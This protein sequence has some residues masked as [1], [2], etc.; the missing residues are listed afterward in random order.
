MRQEW[1]RW[2]SAWRT[3]QVALAVKS[4]AANAGDIR[5]TGS[6][7]G[8]GRSPGEGMAIHSSVLAWRTP[9]TE[10]PG[11]LQSTGSHRV[12]HDWSDLV[13]TV[14]GAQLALPASYSWGAAREG[15]GLKVMD[16][17]TSKVRKGSPVWLLKT[18]CFLQRSTES[19]CHASSA[20][21]P[22]H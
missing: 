19:N 9:C 8:S 1:S 17:C 22:L 3:S 6:I 16:A 14:P 10:K 2:Y 4:P 20:W 18:H 12:R 11:R 13:H 5:D 15:W 21:I 7:P